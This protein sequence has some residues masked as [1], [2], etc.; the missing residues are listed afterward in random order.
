[1]RFKNIAV[2]I[3]IAI[4]CL[5]VDLWAKTGQSTTAQQTEMPFWAIV[6]PQNATRTIIWQIWPDAP[7]EVSNINIKGIKSIKENEPFEED[8]DWLK[9][10]RF[11]IKNR[12]EKPIT[13]MRVDIYFPE[14]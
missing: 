2:T 4:A 12:S 11:S 1:M 13:F 3:L 6:M 8:S 7:Y 14:T 9:Q 5:T 10:L